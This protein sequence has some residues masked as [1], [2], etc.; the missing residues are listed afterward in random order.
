MFDMREQPG[1]IPLSDR[2]AG[3][4]HRV[5]AAQTR[6]I[7]TTFGPRRP[8]LPSLELELPHAWLLTPDLE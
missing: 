5:P 7:G 3:Q 1:L 6:K 8:V 4:R 2:M